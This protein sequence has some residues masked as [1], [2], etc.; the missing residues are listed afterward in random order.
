MKLTQ[1]PNLRIE[2]FPVEQQSWLG[3]LFIQLNPFIQ[4]INQIFDKNIE[5]TTNIKSVSKDYTITSFAPF[6]FTWPYSD[7]TPISLSIVKALKGT[8]NT[9]T[10]L[11]AAWSFDAT[12]LSINVARMAEVNDASVSS[13]SGRYQF[14][15]RVTV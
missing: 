2:D 4:T 10:I 5:Y 7:V 8:G 12:N 15:I 14:T 6:S 3:Q 11:L 13:L 1:V 9:P